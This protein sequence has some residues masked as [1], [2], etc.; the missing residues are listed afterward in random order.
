MSGTCF[1][2]LFFMPN[3]LKCDFTVAAS[4]FCAEQFH[5]CENGSCGNR[6]VCSLMD[7]AIRK[8]K[9]L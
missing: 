6:Y 4:P 1:S 2:F 3:T 7:T 5:K 8:G 9:L